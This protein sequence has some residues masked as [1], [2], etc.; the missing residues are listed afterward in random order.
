VFDTRRGPRFEGNREPALSVSRGAAASGLRY[1]RG[2]VE[3]ADR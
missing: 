2:I 3:K 1:E